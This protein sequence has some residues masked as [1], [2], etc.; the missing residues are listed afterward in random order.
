MLSCSS[1]RHLTAFAAT[2]LR[3][4]SLLWEGG[5][6]QQLQTSHSMSSYAPEEPLLATG[7]EEMAMPGANCSVYQ[8]STA[9][10]T[11]SAVKARS[12]LR[13][14][15][16]S[17]GQRI[18]KC[19]ASTGSVRGRYMPSARGAPAVDYHTATS[20]TACRKVLLALACKLLAQFSCLSEHCEGVRPQ[21]AMQRTHARPLL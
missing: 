10:K 19:Q 11:P 13:R 14:P 9:L 1:S 18:S 21:L 17:D 8:N 3:K 15:L 2:H 7:A 12:R 20:L 4:E 16:S 5:G 6:M